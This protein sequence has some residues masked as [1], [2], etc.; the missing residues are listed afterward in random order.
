MSKSIFIAGTATDIGKTYVSAL[1][2]KKLRQA[3]VNAG[4]YKAAASGVEIDVNGKL[5]GGDPIYVNEIAQIGEDT[6]NLVSYVYKEA[7]SPH[8]A[9]RINNRLIDMKVIEQD[10]DRVRAKYE[11]VVVEGSG[12]VIC[13]LKWEAT[14]HV[15]TLDI[16][17]RLNLPILLIADAGLGT[18]NATVLTVEYLKSHGYRIKGI[19]MNRYINDDMCADNL[20]MIEQ[21]TEL[22]VAAKISVGDMNL[23]IKI[24]ELKKMFE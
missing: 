7:V 23:D 20:Q 6:T 1:V 4:Y 16:V 9:A 2:V 19:I 8:L 21:M 14:E 22:K 17:K 12:G 11:Y 5:T 10:Y 24:D 18:I 13:P 15:T 3:G